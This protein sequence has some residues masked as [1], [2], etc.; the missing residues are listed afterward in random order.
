MLILWKIIQRIVSTG[1][2]VKYMLCDKISNF[3][4]K[5]TYSDNSN[6]ADTTLNTSQLE[7][8]VV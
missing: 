5:N 4:L 1:N 2:G 6:T 3:F 8:S 7:V